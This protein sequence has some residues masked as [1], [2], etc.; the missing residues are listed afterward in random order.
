M[1]THLECLPCFLNM[2]LR[3]V[4]TA[5]PGEV[6]IHEK[7]LKAWA[8]G[9]AE[10]D[11]TN[12]P[13]ELVGRFFR[14]TSS[15]IGGIDIFKDYKDEA[16]ARVLEL[17][18]EVRER[19]L[20]SDDVLL[21]AM[22][23]SIL[24]NYM[25][26]SVAGNFNWEDEL[27]QMEKGIDRELYQEFLDKVFNSGKLMILGDN[28]GEI[29]LD[30]ILVGLLK[31][32]GVEVTYV[33]RGSHILNDATFEDAKLVGMMDI[34]EVITSGVD[35]PGTVLPVCTDEFVKRFEKAGVILSKGQGNFE[36]LWGSVPGVYYA[37]KVKCPVVAE[38]TGHPI[39][40]SLFC[41]EN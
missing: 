9:F 28:A 20:Q 18:P 5:C 29:G 37:F 25:D 8:K 4:R 22:G 32:K 39:R 19:V 35:T 13:P 24:G 14:E 33:V 31:E 7:V 15:L 27:D 16:N 40:T 11:L 6:D 41:K 26:S 34:C 38:I 10:A 21:A 30:T 23:I 3:G 12:S 17:L 36:A 2:T 1:K